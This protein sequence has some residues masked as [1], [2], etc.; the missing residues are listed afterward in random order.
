MAI[1]TARPQTRRA[2]LA[3]T[4]GSLAAVVA[5]ALGRPIPARAEGETV[6]VGGEYWNATSRTYIRNQT[7]HDQVFVAHSTRQG[8]GVTGMSANA[9]GVVG[10]SNVQFGVHGKSASNAGVVGTST[11]GHG[12]IGSSTKGYGAEFSGGR[13]PLRL[14]PKTTPGRPTTGSHQKGEIYMDVDGL[15]YVCVVGGTP[16]RWMMVTMTAA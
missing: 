11:S 15:L 12:V 5:Q 7:N 10:S 4:V 13:A 1:D 6:K 3:A 14:Y 16:G 8:V 2:L 9:N